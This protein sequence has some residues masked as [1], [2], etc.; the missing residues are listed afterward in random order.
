M[1]QEKKGG[2]DL[3]GANTK[4]AL[5]YIRELITKCSSD[6]LN[7]KKEEFTA[8]LNLIDEVESR[9]VDLDDNK[10]KAMFYDYVE[11]DLTTTQLRKLL[12]KVA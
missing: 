8:V 3:T 6:A 9:L 2:I 12:S 11:K 10:K 4:S 7:V 5:N 1:V